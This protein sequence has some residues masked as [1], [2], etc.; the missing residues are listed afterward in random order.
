M[1][2][3][4]HSPG[5]A[6]DLSHINTNCRAKG[7]GPGELADALK[8][9]DLVLVAAGV[10]RKAGQTMQ[11]QFVATSRIMKDLAISCARENP[12]AIYGLISH[13]VSR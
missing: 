4:L 3:V 8:G 13:P 7:Y 10:P 5:V 11:D 1:Y 9:A 2:D 12:T 6:A